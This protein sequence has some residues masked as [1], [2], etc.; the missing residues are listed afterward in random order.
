MKIG[1]VILRLRYIP[2]ATAIIEMSNSPFALIQYW[3]A[4][5]SKLPANRN[6]GID[7]SRN[8]PI[9]NIKYEKI[10]KLTYSQYALMLLDKRQYQH[11]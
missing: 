4:A 3:V 10:S 6:A 5:T 9:R 7:P 11:P 8:P 2:T 1:I